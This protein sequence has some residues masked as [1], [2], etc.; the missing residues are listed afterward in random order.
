MFFKAHFLT[1]LYQKFQKRLK[2]KFHNY[3]F[4]ELNSRDFLLLLFHI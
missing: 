3:K 1:D 2:N 4:P